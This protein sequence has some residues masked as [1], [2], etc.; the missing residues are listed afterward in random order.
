[1]TVLADQLV[2]L[3]PK[4]E[5]DVLELQGNTVTLGAG[6]KDG[7]RPGLE[8]ALFREGREI[9]HPKTGQVL[10]KTEE[11][12]G[13]VT[14]TS[15]QEQFSQGAVTVAGSG[16]LRPGDRFRISA[17]KIRLVLVP[18]TGGVRD[19]L[20]ET[21]TQELVERLNASGRFTVTMGDQVNLF[22]AEQGI[23]A[24]DFLAGRGVKEA[25]QRYRFEHLL[26]V[27]FKRVQSK[28]FMEARFFSMPVTEPL[29]SSSAFVPPSIRAL[30]ER[31]RFS[32]ART[33]ANRPQ[34]KQR[35]LLQ[36]LLGGDLE[37]GS[38]SSGEGT[39]P[40]KEVGRL[41]FAVVAMDIAVQPKDRLPRVVVSDGDRV[42]QYKIVGQ[43]V[44]A[45]WSFSTR[46]LGRVFSLQL[47]DLDGDGIFEIVGNR[48]HVKAG[49]NSFIL[50]AKDGKPKFLVDT[51]ESFLFAVDV[52]GEGVKQTLWAQRYNPDTFFTI[53]QADEVVVKKGSLD[54]VKQ[55][56][57]PST[58]RPMGAT[59]S[60]IAGKDTRALALVDEA[61]R[62]RISLDG[63][64]IWRSS[65]SVGGGY[66][67]MELV[68]P[69]GRQ[70]D[71]TKFYKI[72]PT[73]LALDLDGDGI[74][75]LV[76]PQNL[77]KEGLLAV[78]FKGP[79]GYRL[80]SIDTGFEGGITA[81]GG[82]RTDDAVQPTMVATV[83]RFNN[84]LNTSGETQI[85]MTLPQE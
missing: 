59:F 49:L 78:V 57:A 83:V 23:K 7:L 65:T 27:Q 12:L 21:A 34:A 31:E 15:V 30:S 33:D 67:K 80:Q 53:G 60:N 5:G 85:I 52:K 3:F 16:E 72:E 66:T 54:V 77:V 20:V 22:L 50:S 19:A 37:A 58:F 48:F 10:G 32:S 26:V 6:R 79:A 64:D 25:A 41:G 76:V 82:F 36:R 18:L 45:E 81:L 73:P 70:G 38:Y 62:L 24:D 42:Y 11:N 1:M 29:V 84:F 13:R 56:R 14:V 40:L 17:G 69:R 8:M 61:N 46:T 68:I 2:D 9:K 74:D 35:S 43:K 63:E 51:V 44:E 39:I 47:A 28:P 71:I 55:V 75:E 4:V